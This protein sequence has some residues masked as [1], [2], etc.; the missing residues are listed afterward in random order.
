MQLMLQVDCVNNVMSLFHPVCS[1][2]G[3][4]HHEL[5]GSP[6]CAL[7]TRSMAK[8]QKTRPEHPDLTPCCRS[9]PTWPCPGRVG[10]SSETGASD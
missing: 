3:S 1:C 4:T 6:T 2:V 10:S 8:T 5:A 9:T 7:G